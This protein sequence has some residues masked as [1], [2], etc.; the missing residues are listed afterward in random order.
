MK[1][2]KYFSVLLAGVLAFPGTTLLADEEV[3][4]HIYPEGHKV[5]I[6]SDH[7]VSFELPG[8]VP[9]GKR[10]KLEFLARIDYPV[11]GGSPGFGLVV[12][13]NDK[14]LP[15]RLLMSQPDRMRLFTGSTAPGDDI[16]LTLG[17][18]GASY[19]FCVEI[20]LTG[21]D[22]DVY[23][24]VGTLEVGAVVDVEGFLYWYQGPNPHVT[25]ITV[26]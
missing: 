19:D 8:G 25:S 9:Q 14:T 24:T 10:V 12:F 5:P 4:S 22:T 21:E 1:N 11:L 26:K 6:M 16:Y 3:I 20:Y 23:Q 15:S 18:N 13:A 2:K 17:Y 7:E